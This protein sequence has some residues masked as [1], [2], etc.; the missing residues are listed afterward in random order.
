[1]GAFGGMKKAEL[2]E[3][4]KDRG[5]S[6]EDLR[7]KKVSE[8]R[9]LHSELEKVKEEAPDALKDMHPLQRVVIE[10]NGKD[11]TVSVDVARILIS[12]GKARLK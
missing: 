11:H 3:I 8:L 12:K 6:K 9:E 4:L 1:M 5:Y 7:E 2:I 10:F